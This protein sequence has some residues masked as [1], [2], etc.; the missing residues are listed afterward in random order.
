M[1]VSSKWPGEQ[2]GRW[3]RDSGWRRSLTHTGIVVDDAE[4]L[5]APLLH[6]IIRADAP[7]HGR[8]SQISPGFM[9]EVPG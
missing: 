9:A 7:E 1:Q 3:V 4:D 6:V 5:V 8:Q 2:A